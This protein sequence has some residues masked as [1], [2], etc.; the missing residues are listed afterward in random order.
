[1][2]GSDS[3]SAVDAQMAQTINATAITLC[4]IIGSLHIFFLVMTIGLSGLRFAILNFPIPDFL[5]RFGVTALPRAQKLQ[6]VHIYRVGIFIRMRECRG[7]R[8]HGCDPR[9]P[10]RHPG[11]PLASDKTPSLRSVRDYPRQARY[12]DPRAVRS[13]CCCRAPVPGDWATTAAPRL[14]RRRQRH[15]EETSGCA[16]KI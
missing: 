16:T 1:M 10:S 13:G 15:Q 8:Q 14:L 3:A 6:K 12:P 4:L 2:P 11:H 5:K 7:E 9:R